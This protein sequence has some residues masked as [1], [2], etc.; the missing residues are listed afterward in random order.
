MPT[1]KTTSPNFSPGRSWND[2]TSVVHTSRQLNIS[3]R[4]MVGTGEDAPIGGLIVSGPTAKQVILRAI[5]PSL[6]A[7]GLTGVLEDPTLELRDST[8]ALIFSNDNWRK[9]QEA[10]IEA[11]GLQPS[12]DRE[13]AIVAMLYRAPT[14][15]SSRAPTTPPGPRWSKP[16][17]SMQQ[18]KRNLPTSALADSSGQ[19]TRP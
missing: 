16:T 17:I 3:T 7:F 8:G 19:T 15:P 6:A 1:A 10:A 4:E 12:D 5:G 18:R 2:P 9:T 14:P 13:A 11:T